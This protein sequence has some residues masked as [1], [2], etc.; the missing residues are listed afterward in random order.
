[1]VA[2]LRVIDATPADATVIAYL[3]HLLDRARAG[4]FSAVAVAYVYRDGRTGSGHSDQHSLP[5]MVGSVAC[6]QAKLIADMLG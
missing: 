1:M 5:T 2:D 6:L 3:E 4:E